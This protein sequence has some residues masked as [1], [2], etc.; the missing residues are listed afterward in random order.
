MEDRTWTIIDELRISPSQLCKNRSPRHGGYGRH[1]VAVVVVAVLVMTM[2]IRPIRA[3]SGRFTG[4]TDHRPAIKHFTRTVTR[5]MTS[6]DDEDDEEND[7]EA[8]TCPGKIGPDIV[9]SQVGQ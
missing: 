8:K 3:C 7:G 2:A 4:H 9:F 5:K 1:T 6:E